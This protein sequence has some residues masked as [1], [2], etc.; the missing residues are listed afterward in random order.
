MKSSRP[1][2]ARGRTR[3]GWASCGWWWEEKPELLDT[4]RPPKI[5]R[6]A[7]LSGWWWGYPC[8]LNPLLPA[9]S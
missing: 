5:E 7:S 3:P 1:G 4:S 9:L 6:L 2:D 8:F